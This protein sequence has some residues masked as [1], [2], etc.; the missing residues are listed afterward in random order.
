MPQN[1]QFFISHKHQADDGLPNFEELQ[2]KEHASGDGASM[3][4]VVRTPPF[5]PGKH[6]PQQ[7]LFLPDV[8]RLHY[9]C[10]I[11]TTPGSRDFD[12]AGVAS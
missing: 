8:C 7:A 1:D 10:P 9:G 11:L 5:Q 2:E 3:S 4:S 6:K 12:E